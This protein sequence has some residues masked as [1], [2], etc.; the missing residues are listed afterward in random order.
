MHGAKVKEK[1][2]GSLGAGSFYVA[3]GRSFKREIF[4][5]QCSM[6]KWVPD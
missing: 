4:N 6:L 1:V 5:N 3:Y 2:E